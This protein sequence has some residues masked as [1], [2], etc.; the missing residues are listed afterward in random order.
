VKTDV[1]AL[2]VE[3]GGVDYVEDV[4]FSEF[5][6]QQLFSHGRFSRNSFL[7]GFFL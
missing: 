7:Q 2:V 6:I 1:K 3:N 5:V 4:V